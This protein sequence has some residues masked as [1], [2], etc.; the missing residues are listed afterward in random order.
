[1]GQPRPPVGPHDN[2][3]STALVGNA[4]NRL[5]WGSG[6]DVRIPG[7]LK[8]GRYEV[9]QLRQGFLVMVM[10]HYPC[11]GRRGGS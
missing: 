10:E 1:M 6:S 4:H 2:E 3:V 9:A 5:R 7:T 11:L 8:G